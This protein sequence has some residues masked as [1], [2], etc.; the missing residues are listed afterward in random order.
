[1]APLPLK[2]DAVSLCW[3]SLRDGR[4]NDREGW[5]RT[6]DEE[7]REFTR[8]RDD[9]HICLQLKQVARF[10]RPVLTWIHLL[11]DLTIVQRDSV[12]PVIADSV[13]PV[14][15]WFAYRDVRYLEMMSYNNRPQKFYFVK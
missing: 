10:S 12:N 1:M 14:T 13:N 11:T 7:K 2:V 8:D 15:D 4:E 3:T 5:N 9:D 6:G